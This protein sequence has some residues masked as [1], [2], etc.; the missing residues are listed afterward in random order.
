MAN[1]FFLGVWAKVTFMCNWNM[2]E[3]RTGIRFRVSRDWNMCRGGYYIFLLICCFSE[4]RHTGLLA[5]GLLMVV[6]L[7]G[8][9]GSINSL[10]L[11]MSSVGRA[12]K[13]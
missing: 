1:F 8:L 2:A 10:W 4:T 3:F 12:S 11:T 9:S 7:S 6:R 13:L 5:S